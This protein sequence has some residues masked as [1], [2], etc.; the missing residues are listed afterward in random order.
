MPR[1]E[2][3]GIRREAVTITKKDLIDR[4]ANQ[5]GYRRADVKQI[6]QAVLDEVTAELGEGSR[7]EFRDFGV[8]D[9]RHRA[10]RIGKNPRT[11]DPVEVPAK[12][13]VRFK[14]GRQLR[15]VM[16]RD[17]I[18][19]RKPS[20]LAGGAQKSVGRNSKAGGS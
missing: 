9:V 16:E 3:S 5:T 7:I 15:E 20:P 8:F 10:A 12:R 14:P 2:N 17:P 13:G 19:Q 11:L 1:Q 4:V 6:L 18:P